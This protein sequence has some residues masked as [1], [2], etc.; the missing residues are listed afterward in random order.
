[1]AGPVANGQ[2]P[3]S[4]PG[5][6][7]HSFESCLFRERVQIKVGTLGNSDRHARCS[8]TC[9]VTLGAHANCSLLHTHTKQECLA[10]VVLWLCSCRS[11]QCLTTHRQAGLQEAGRVKTQ[12]GGQERSSIFAFGI[13][14]AD[15]GHQSFSPL[16]II[17][18][19][20]LGRWVEQWQLQIS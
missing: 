16:V 13:L 6:S 15:A 17:P 2:Q 7:C 19:F 14:S 3:F 8:Q 11:H 10:W 5:D 18:E 12:P 1:M 20:P 9:R 4:V